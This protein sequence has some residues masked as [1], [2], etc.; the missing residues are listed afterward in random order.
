MSRGQVGSHSRQET[1]ASRVKRPLFGEYQFVLTCE[2][3]YHTDMLDSRDEG[4]REDIVSEVSALADSAPETTKT[5]NT[6]ATVLRYEGAD[7]AKNGDHEGSVENRYQY[8]D[9]SENDAETHHLDPCPLQ[10]HAE[11]VDDENHRDCQPSETDSSLTVFEDEIQD[12]SSTLYEPDD[13]EFESDEESWAPSE[14][15]NDDSSSES[16]EDSSSDES[17]VWSWEQNVRIYPAAL[18]I[19]AIGYIQPPLYLLPAVLP[20]AQAPEDLPEAIPEPTSAPQSSLPSAEAASL[21]HPPASGSA[22]AF[23]NFIQVHGLNYGCKVTAIS[24]TDDEENNSSSDE[25]NR[26]EIDVVEIPV[27]NW[28]N[29][30]DKSDEDK[31]EEG[32]EDYGAFYTGEDGDNEW[33]ESDD[34][35]DLD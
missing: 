12:D 3:G 20:P 33:E 7:D 2:C 15:S 28:S 32:R 8:R 17:V 21:Q 24:D 26:S 5:N 11:E 16:S 1:E 27:C 35:E 19:S 25:E 29:D 14:L 34:Y 4:E 22:R 13:D 10:P 30:E 9:E 23:V 18:H 6:D 31:D